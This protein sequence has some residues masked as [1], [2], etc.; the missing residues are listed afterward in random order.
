MVA[1]VGRRRSGHKCICGLFLH[2]CE[3]PGALR[4]LHPRHRP[5]PPPIASPPAKLANNSLPACPL[6]HQHHPP[7]CPGVPLSPLQLTE[8][9][10]GV[11]PEAEVSTVGLSLQR[12]VTYAGDAG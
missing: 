8:S 2:P 12:N 11:V 4:S 5:C 6:T 1:A 10:K 9:V 7:R 3:P